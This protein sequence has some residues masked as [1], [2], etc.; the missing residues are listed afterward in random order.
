MPLQ[1][2]RQINIENTKKPNGKDKPKHYF[3]PV[4]QQK[5]FF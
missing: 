2:M 5:K 4:F 3:N 1:I